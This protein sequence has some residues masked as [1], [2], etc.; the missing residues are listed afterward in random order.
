MESYLLTKEWKQD[1]PECLRKI[2]RVSADFQQIIETRY[3]VRG[4]EEIYRIFLCQLKAEVYWLERLLN[5]L[6]EEGGD[7]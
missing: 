5:A 6:I 7:Q 3:S 1:I 2:S 4:T